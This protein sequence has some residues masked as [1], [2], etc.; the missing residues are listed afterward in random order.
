[1]KIMDFAPSRKMTIKKDESKT[2]LHCKDKHHICYN[3]RE[4]GNLFNDCPMGNLFV[5]LFF[6]TAESQSKATQMLYEKDLHASKH[7]ILLG[8][9]VLERKL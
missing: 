2:Q 8:L 6:M 3:C 7:Q 5:S 1:M 9:M 4:K